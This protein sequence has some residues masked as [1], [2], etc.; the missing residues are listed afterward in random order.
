MFAVNIQKE[1]YRVGEEERKLYMLFDSISHSSVTELMLQIF[2][3]SS[4]QKHDFYGWSKKKTHTHT[5]RFK[6]YTDSLAKNNTNE[7]G[8]QSQKIHPEPEKKPGYAA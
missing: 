7:L 8:H 5:S 6:L 3:N 1:D 4:K 2:L